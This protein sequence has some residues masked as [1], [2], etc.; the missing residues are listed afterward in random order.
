MKV[1]GNTVGTTLNPNKLKDKL[2]PTITVTSIPGGHRVTITDVNGTKS[3]DIMNGTGGGVTLDLPIA[4]G[5]GTGAVIIGDIDNNVAS[6]EFSL[7]SGHNTKATGKDATA[8]GHL[9]VA[10]GENSYAEGYNCKASNGNCHAEGGTTKAEGNNSHSQNYY[11]QALEDFT[12]A[13]GFRTVSAGV[14]SHSQGIGINGIDKAIPDFSTSTPIETIKN[15]WKSIKFLLAKGRASHAGGEDCLALGNRTFA[16]G[17]QCIAEHD[18]SS[19]WGLRT[20]TSAKNQSV[21]GKYNA[22]E[23]TALDIVG[24]GTSDTNRRNCYSSG[25]DENGEAYLKI[26]TTKITEAQLI[27]LLA[28]NSA[29]P[30]MIAF[31]I[32]G[33]EY[34]AEAGM[35]WGEWCDDKRYNTNGY[36]YDTAVYDGSGNPVKYSDGSSVYESHEIKAKGTYRVDKP[37][38]FTIDGTEYEADNAYT[39]WLTWC[40]G[41]TYFEVEDGKVKYIKSG[42]P[43]VDF[44]VIDSSGNKLTES[45]F[46]VSGAEYK[47]IFSFEIDNDEYFAET[48]MSW[49]QWID[50]TSYNIDSYQAIDDTTGIKY[51]CNREG[52]GIVADSSDDYQAVDYS[53]TPGFSYKIIDGTVYSLRRS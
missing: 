29:T 48:G 26:G 14:A 15:A 27:K 9:T 30:T 24:C 31:T 19:A 32:D 2:S 10:S 45:L 41:Q 53:I 4:K 13:Q 46:I 6:G 34:E 8:R 52:T 1:R 23:S 3:F 20:R 42:S 33:T 28:E 16:H 38:R 22:D 51:V 49:G 7:A 37:I 21:R 43:S 40:R 17:Y 18:E 39:D 12:H 36:L 11:T 35:T 47:T 50:D 5:T 25:V 44:Y